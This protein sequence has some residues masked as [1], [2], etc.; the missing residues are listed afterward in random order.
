MTKPSILVADDDDDMRRLLVTTF[1][2]DGYVVR[3]A[4]SGTDLLDLLG[5]V[6]VFER[7][8]VIVADVMMPG[9]TGLEIL[10]AV[11]SAGWSTPI[12]LISAHRNAQLRAD[13]ARLGVTAFIQKPLDL[14]DLRVAVATALWGDGS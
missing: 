12:V 3:T 4:A 14:A 13:A 6:T 9:Y 1:E 5:K 8:D 11:R 2:S 10:G 7:P